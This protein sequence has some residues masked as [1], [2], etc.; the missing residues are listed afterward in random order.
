MLVLTSA[1]PGS[2]TQIP[3]C[4]RRDD[5][6]RSSHDESTSTPPMDSR[7]MEHEQEG[8]LV[9]GVVGADILPEPGRGGQ[10]RS[11]RERYASS[12]YLLRVALLK[13]TFKHTLGL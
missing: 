10:G 11:V 12:V 13:T 9:R 5:F 6:V 2:L 1:Q 7:E 3:T 4:Y 8:A